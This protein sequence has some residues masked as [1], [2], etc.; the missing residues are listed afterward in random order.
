MLGNREMFPERPR[1]GQGMPDDPQKRFPQLIPPTPS[2]AD[3]Q[4]L[5]AR[6]Q[7]EDDAD[8]ATG[9]DPLTLFAAWFAKA[10]KAEPR[11]ANAM[12][13]ATVDPAG[14][15]DAR[16]VLLK[17]V[18]EGGFVF[19]TN[20]ESAKGRQLANNANA[21]LVFHWK[22]LNRQVRISG[23]VAPVA[24]GEADVYFATRARD[25]RIGAWASDQS[26]PMEAPMALEAR[27][28]KFAARFGLSEVPRPPHWS[29]F[30]LTP[31]RIE[32]WRERP[33]RLHERRLFERDA[34]GAPWRVSR[35]FP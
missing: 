9:D 22:S 5:R 17:D 28:A 24:S 20:L 3:Y 10:A 18:S 16:M 7:A 34:P 33:F 14:A 2:E 23:A 25:A 11:D 21:A 32:F 12:T 8:A 6:A 19:Y 29:G 27:V 31:L 4:L 1:K 15:P 13:L 30:R 35:L 26:R